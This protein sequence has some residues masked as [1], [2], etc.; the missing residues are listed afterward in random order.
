MTDARNEKLNAHKFTFFVIVFFF[1]IIII[2]LYYWKYC[3][4]HKALF[5]HMPLHNPTMHILFVDLDSTSLE[6]M[7]KI[8][9]RQGI[10]N[11]AIPL[12]ILQHRSIFTH[13]AFYIL[14]SCFEDTALIPGL[15][16]EKSHENIASHDLSFHS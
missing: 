6:E 3:M 13:E 14:T 8:R 12:E 15:Y 5:W 4:Y 10:R 16:K 7:S 11:N 9:C 2:I 1:I